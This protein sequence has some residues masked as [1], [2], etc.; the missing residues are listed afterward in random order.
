MKMP[1][2]S[3]VALLT[4]ALWGC[5]RSEKPNEPTEDNAR[6]AAKSRPSEHLHFR[7]AY[8]DIAPDFAQFNRAMKAVES[9][10]R[11]KQSN[12]TWALEGPTNIGG[13]INSV[14][15]HPENEA[16][17]YAGTCTGGVFKT[18]DGGATWSPLSDGFDHLPIAHIIFHPTDPETLL[19]A[20]GDPNISGFPHPGN[21]IYRTTDGGA[22][23]THIGPDING[24]V[25]KVAYDPQNPTTIYAALMGL[26]FERNNDR[27]L[28]KSSDEGASW[29]QVLFLSDEV[30]IT[31]LKINYDN[32]NIIYAAGWH[33]IRNNQESVIAGELSR[34]YKSVDGGAN[35]ETLTNGFPDGNLCRIGLEMSVNDPNVVWALV[36]GTNFEAQGIYKT[37]DGG[38]SWVNLLP[39][40]ELLAGTLG[41]FGWYFGKIRVNP[42]NESEISILG[43]DLHTS[44][45]NG[46]SWQMTT[47]PWW[48][49]EVHADKHDMVY[50]DSETVV[51]AT[52]GGLYRTDDHFTTWYD[53][54]NIPNTQFYRIALN[55]FQTGFYTGGAQ[56]NGTTT[57]NSET[58]NDWTRDFGGDGFQAAFDPVVPERRY[59]ET[60]NGNIYVDDFGNVFNI[61]ETLIEGDRR[62]WDMPYIISHTNNELLYTGTY[63]FYRMNDAPYGSWE[64]MSDDLTDGNVFGSQYHTISTVAESQTNANH[65]FVGTT[66]GNVWRGELQFDVFAWTSISAGL[67]DRYVT[68]IK[69]S[70]TTPERIWV[71]QSGYKDNDQTARL[72]RSDNN[73]ATWMD[74]T[75]DLPPHAINHIEVLNDSL[76]FIA[77]DFGVYYTENGGEAWERIGNNMPLI[78]V[79]DIEIEHETRRL[80]AGT[81]ARGMWSFDLELLF[82]WPEDEEEP[83]HVAART[84]QH[85]KVYPNPCTAYTTLCGGASNCSVQVYDMRGNRVLEV[86]KLSECITLNLESLPNGKYVMLWGKNE[87]IQTKSF[88]K[89]DL[90]R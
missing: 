12:G 75:G 25:S 31:D 17:M 54:D 15:I 81:F 11:T 42:F 22:T 77:T 70:P 62:N 59:V 63:R 20:T 74:V 36:V 37:E 83:V 80:I 8:P 23:W 33:R 9:T 56:D 21:G 86:G 52:D 50:L 58:L 55:P 73:G 28:Y 60:Q 68:N 43:V 30:G 82:E 71:S 13:R 89:A 19:V 44:Y 88:I 69:S 26:P 7:Y 39:D 49:Y 65:V 10:Q 5:Q 57:G 1:H 14:A 90:A 32:P 34:V 40:P 6:L 3:S 4:L 64:V 48:M 85:S 78:P 29:E 53:I 84:S 18:L 2:W 46:E 67:P 51:L 38:A 66:D 87:E 16:I 45:D 72:H 76:L 41:G 27:G 61:S 35:W 47:P 24:V 79:Y